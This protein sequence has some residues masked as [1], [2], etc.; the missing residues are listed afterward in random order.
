LEASGWT[1]DTQAESQIREQGQQAANAQAS[2]AAATAQSQATQQQ[3]SQDQQT[4]EAGLSTL[5][6]DASLSSDST[7]HAGPDTVVVEGLVQWR[8][9][10]R[11]YGSSTAPMR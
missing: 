1:E 2:A 11:R 6:S 5:Q 7:L 10:R 9:Q 8:L 4:A 3:D